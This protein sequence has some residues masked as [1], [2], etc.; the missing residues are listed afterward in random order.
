MAT[1]PMVAELTELRTKLEIAERRN[2]ELDEQLAERD[3]QIAG[4]LADADSDFDERV[5][6]R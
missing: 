5:V 3:E 1:D 4:L 2:K 6:P